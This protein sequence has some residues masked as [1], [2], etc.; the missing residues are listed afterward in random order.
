MM[1]SNPFPS[2][3]D[4]DGTL[5]YPQRRWI[6]K[7]VMP[8]CY[9]AGS[10]KSLK[11]EEISLKIKEIRNRFN[12]PGSVV[13]SLHD[14]LQH[15]AESDEVV[16][17]F[18]QLEYGLL[19]PIDAEM[20][21]ILT[22][23]GIS[24]QQLHPSILVSIRRLL[25]IARVF[26]R[27]LLPSD[28]HR[29]I[30]PTPRD[31]GKGA[32]ICFICTW[33]D[34]Q[35]RLYG[36]P[37]IYKHWELPCFKFRNW[38]NDHRLGIPYKLASSSL[39]CGRVLPDF[40]SDERIRKLFDL[41]TDLFNVSYPDS[42]VQLIYNRERV[43]GHVF[44]AIPAVPVAQYHA[45]PSLGP[46]SQDRA[47]SKKRCS[48]FSSSSGFPRI[49]RK[50]RCPEIG[51]NDAQ[52]SIPKTNNVREFRR[53]R[54]AHQDYRPHCMNKDAGFPNRNVTQIPDILCRRRYEKLLAAVNAC[55]TKIIIS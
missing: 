3:E 2:S 39:K 53:L 36:F 4:E 13:I 1:A 45:P 44:A 14:S 31:W 24:I 38:K 43:F 25:T 52:T 40:E 8:S 6:P 30:S 9:V 27:H 20:C 21:E 35:R 51:R 28:V 10:F 26:C 12:I 46:S 29:I 15:P 34:N 54:K 18:Y 11:P 17:S 55:F 42:I 33:V 22:S 49:P 5:D 19:M 16:A 50:R 48:S 37:G 7:G 32:G 23:W 41:P 47:N